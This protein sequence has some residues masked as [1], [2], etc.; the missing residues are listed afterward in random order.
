M[1]TWFNFTWIQLLINGKCVV[2]LGGDKDEWSSV[3]DNEE[4]QDKQEH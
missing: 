3:G 2:I 1:L 4:I